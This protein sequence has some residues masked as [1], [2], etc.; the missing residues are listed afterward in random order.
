MLE[1]LAMA[2]EDLTRDYYGDLDAQ[3]RAEY[4][5]NPNERGSIDWYLYATDVHARCT[6]RWLDRSG[7]L[8]K[9]V[10]APCLAIIVAFEFYRLVAFR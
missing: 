4:D 7:R 1:T 6:R 9:Y 3:G 8:Q 10:I 2:K 5:A